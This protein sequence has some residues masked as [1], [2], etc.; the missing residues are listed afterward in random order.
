MRQPA[1]WLVTLAI[2]V[3]LA[4]L[5]CVLVFPRLLH[6]PLS[7]SELQGVAS[8]DRR[9]ELQQAQ[10]KLQ[11][12]A[13]ATLLQAIAGLLLVAGAVATWRQVQ[14]TREGHMTERFA[15]AVDQL[16]SHKPD[17]RLGGMY[18]LE[19]I[20]RNSP[21]EGQTVAAVLAAIVRTHAPWL[22]GAPGGPTHPSPV[23]GGHQPWLWKRAPEV[24]QAMSVLG[25][26]DRRPPSRDELPLYLSRVDLR[27]ALLPGARLSDARIRHA[28]FARSQMPRVRLENSDL[29]NTDLRKANLQDA[30]LTGANLRHSHLQDADLRG[31]KLQGANLQGAHLDSADLTGA[32]LDATTVWLDGT[33]G[34]AAPP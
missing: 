31:A 4:L 14:V 5:A 28:N 2:G 30:R 13:R 22:V 10:A 15:R 1:G 25:M 17:V 19:R 23:V 26:L 32:Q 16:G 34:H 18:T 27:G 12:D 29:E 7:P 6:P 21:A 11:N 3:V 8:A 20:A 33:T 9:I 24:Q